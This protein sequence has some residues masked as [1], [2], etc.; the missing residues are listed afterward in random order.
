MDNL[1]EV[2]NVFTWMKCCTKGCHKIAEAG[3]LTISTG[4]TVQKWHA[5]FRVEEYFPLFRKK[6]RQIPHYVVANWGIAGEIHKYVQENIDTL[7]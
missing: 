5:L 4:E 2:N 3:T 1:N 6:K 7:G